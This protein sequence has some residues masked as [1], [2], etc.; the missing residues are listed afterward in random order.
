MNDLGRRLVFFRWH[1]ID[2]FPAFD[3]AGCARTITALP[4]N[5]NRKLPRG[6]FAADVLVHAVGGGSKPTL[7]SLLRLRDFENRPWLRAPGETAHPAQMRR[8]EDLVDFAQVVIWSDSYAVFAQGGH[9]PPPSGLVDF[10][11]RRAEQAVHFSA[12]YERDVVERMR[13]WRGIRTVNLLIQ[14]SRTVQEQINERIG[15]F[16]GFL[17]QLRGQP[18]GVYLRHEIAVPKRGRGGRSRVLA[19]IDT[20]DVIRLAEVAESFDAFTVS[21][22]T[23]AGR[24]ETVDL[25]RQ[26]LQ[27]EAR[28]PRSPQGG[29]RTDDAATFEALLAARHEVEDDGR[30]ATAAEAT[31]PS[32]ETE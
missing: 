26:R 32:P 15:P 4:D 10:C 18:D 28:L 6:E 11:A 5:A 12:L 13:A 2:G 16:E 21:G 25:I 22:I 27:V 3:P 31:V 30:L 7:L 1:S 8:E 24:I 14:N 29:H 9:A 20:A 23:R 19:A 17:S